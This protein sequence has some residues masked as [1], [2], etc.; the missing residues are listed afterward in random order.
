LILVLLSLSDHKSRLLLTAPFNP[1]VGT[2]RA[3]KRA[4]PV[5][6]IHTVSP[7]SGECRKRVDRLPLS[8]TP[9]ADFYIAVRRPHDL[10]SLESGTRCRSPEVSTTAFSAQ[11]PDLRFMLLMDM[12][13]VI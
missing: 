3:F 7:L 8:T 5:R 13:F 1:S 10:L 2:V 12:D 6:R 11:P 4:F 9:S